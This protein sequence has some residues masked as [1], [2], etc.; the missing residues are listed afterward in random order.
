MAFFGLTYCGPQNVFQKCDLERSMDGS[1]A[2]GTTTLT[3]TVA[4][5]EV[6]ASRKALE[7]AELFEDDAGYWLLKEALKKRPTRAAYVSA[8]RMAEDK[9][10]YKM[11]LTAPQ[12]QWV[13]PLTSNH[14]IGWDHKTGMGGIVKNTHSFPIC[15][16]EE[17]RFQRVLLHFNHSI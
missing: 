5:Q 12:S 1:M 3:Q 11:P 4:Q 8:R 7:E 16:S 14:D 13:E 6:E 2:N 17:T 10:A 15:S 9:R